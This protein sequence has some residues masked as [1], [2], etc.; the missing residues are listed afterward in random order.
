VLFSFSFYFHKNFTS[1][2][3]GVFPYFAATQ[4]SYA[5]DVMFQGINFVECYYTLSCSI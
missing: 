1:G 2:F 5:I 3:V 4:M